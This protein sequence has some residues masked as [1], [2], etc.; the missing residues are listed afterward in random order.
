MNAFTRKDVYKNIQ[1][2]F[3]HN[4]HKKWKQPKLPSTGE[5]INIVSFFRQGML[6][7]IGTRFRFMQLHGLNQMKEAKPKSTDCIVPFT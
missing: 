5:W 3:I 1:S 7:K 2:S 4:A 6:L